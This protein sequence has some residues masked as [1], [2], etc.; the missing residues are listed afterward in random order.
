MA[1]SK[2][3]IKER[4]EFVKYWADYIKKSPNSKWSKEHA[5]FINSV[6]RSADVNPKTM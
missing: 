2:T 4:L 3:D 6:M 5:K 1:L